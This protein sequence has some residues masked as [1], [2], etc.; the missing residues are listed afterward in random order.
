MRYNKRENLVVICRKRGEIMLKRV[1][2]RYLQIEKCRRVLVT[3]DI[4][5]SLSCLKNALKAAEFSED[6]ILVIV[7]DMTEKG[8]DSLGTLRYIMKLSEAGNVYTLIGN[9]DAWRLLQLKRMTPENVQDFFDYVIGQR[10]W[11]CPALFDDLTREMGFTCQSPE[12]MLEAKVKVIC[13][14]EKE[15]GFL[16]SLPTIIETSNYIFVHGGLRDKCL[17]DN[18]QRDAFD[19]MKYDDFMS[20]DICFD[21]YVVA[22]HWPVNLYTVDGMSMAPVIDKEKKIISIDG[23]CGIKACGQVNVLIIP[24]IDSPV[25]DIT[26]VSGDDLPE[27]IAL[28]DQEEVPGSFHLK[29]T[30]DRITPLDEQG[31]MARILHKNTGRELLI[32]ASYV[33]KDGRCID[34]TDHQLSVKAGDKLKV[35]DNLPGGYFVKKGDQVGLYFGDICDK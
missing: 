15:I 31:G 22:G 5:G 3:S 33:L 16:E 27:S 2:Y 21:K 17:E 29:W 4:H 18:L 6:D 34:Y 10:K 23:G 7:G 11:N 20:T 12:E 26:H 8:P 19:L 24:H 14:A 30:S 25:E 32:P 28:S 9:V 1:D 35:F 13:Y